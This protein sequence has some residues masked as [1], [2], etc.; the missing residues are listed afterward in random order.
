MK[1]ADKLLLYVYSVIIKLIF[2]DP[3]HLYSVV[4]IVIEPMVM[5]TGEFKT[6]KYNK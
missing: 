5:R 3:V 2:S 4:T 6:M 1:I